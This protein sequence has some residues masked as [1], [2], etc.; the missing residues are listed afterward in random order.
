MSKVLFIQKEEMRCGFVI[1]EEETC[2][3]GL[4][5]ICLGWG[6]PTCPG[7]CFEKAQGKAALY[8]GTSGYC[9]W[10]GRVVFLHARL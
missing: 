8:T 4:A 10:L 3:A 6:V 2:C 1:K 7:A 5:E 9:F